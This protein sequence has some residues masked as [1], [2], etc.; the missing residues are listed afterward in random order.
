[1]N[2]AVSRSIAHII[3]VTEKYIR[4]QKETDG[5]QKGTPDR[6]RLVHE[7]REAREEYE[8]AVMFSPHTILGICKAVQELR[9]P[10]LCGVCGG[11]GKP[12]SG[13]PCV[14]SGVGTEQAEMHGLRV[15]VFELQ[16]EL[17]KVAAQ[18]DD[19]KIMNWMDDNP[20]KAVD[21]LRYVANDGE[22]VRTEVKRYL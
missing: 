1:M 2:E 13:L 3:A 22:D 19:T 6:V 7:L 16:E 11:T 8:N 5:A 15:M 12:V 20:E 10:I 21:L 4:V 9:Q 17:A 18:T 14:C